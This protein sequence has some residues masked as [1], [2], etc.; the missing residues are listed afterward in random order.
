MATVRR[1]R[2]VRVLVAG[3]IVA[4]AAA[5]ISFATWD[6]SDGDEGRSPASTGVPGAPRTTQEAPGATTTAPRQ[7]GVSPEDVGPSRPDLLRPTGPITV[8]T[9]GAVIENVDVDGP[10][11]VEAPDVT[12]RNFRATNVVQ[13]SAGGLLLEDG[14]IH[15]GDDPGFGADGVA[16]S[17]Y[18]AR[19][20]DVHHVFDGFK[21]N[22]DVLI[23]DSWVHDLNEFRGDGAGSGGYSHNDCVQI[24]AGS[25]IV[26][27]D[28]R[29]ERCGLN[30][31]VFID[32]DQGPIDDVLVE[33]NLLDGG[34]YT[35]YAIQSRSA[36]ENGPPTAVVVRGNTFGPDHLVD[37]ATVA[38]TVEWSGN[39]DGDGRPV[40]PVPDELSG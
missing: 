38:G 6:R 17:S 25:D 11:V 5:G 34:G 33:G 9:P 32:P 28:N 12:I 1:R 40:E 19:R 14:E 20:L 30:S 15:G 24:S 26:L 29:F 7:A 35:L 36:P 18:T 10:I 2:R 4:A 39:V 21:A 23:E 13:E 16:W 27:R 22:G 3:G 8:S 31:A 37:H